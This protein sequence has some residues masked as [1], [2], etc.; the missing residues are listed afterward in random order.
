MLKVRYDE[1]DWYW[2]TFH[3]DV[4]WA[5]YGY[6]NGKMYQVKTVDDTDYD[7]M[8]NA[9]P[10]CKPNGTDDWKECICESYK[11]L[12]CEL[13]EMTTLDILKMRWKKACWYN[14]GL[15][16]LKFK[17]RH[18]LEKTPKEKQNV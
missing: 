14:F 11:D 9:C 13:T 6:Y 3:Y 15:P 10:C 4:H 1:V 7:A 8:N 12:N 17:M 18:R 5:G 16:Y 2:H